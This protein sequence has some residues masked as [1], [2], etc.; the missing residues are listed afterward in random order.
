VSVPKRVVLSLEKKADA[1]RVHFGLGTPVS[2][3]R[4]EGPIELSFR[5]LLIKKLLSIAVRGWSRNGFGDLT[6]RINPVSYA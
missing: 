1:L 3:V 2:S 4:E 5:I 6:V